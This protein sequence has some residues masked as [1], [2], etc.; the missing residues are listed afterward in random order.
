MQTTIQLD[1]STVQVLNNLKE[2]HKV[3]SYNRLI[4]ILIN[5]E[6]KVPKSLFGAH[7]KMK[8]FKRDRDDFHDL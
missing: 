5:K 3:E 7:P 4:Q 8:S 6:E 2:K 1:K